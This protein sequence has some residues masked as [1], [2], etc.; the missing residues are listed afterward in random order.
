[1][2]N[3]LKAK[4]PLKKHQK[5]MLWITLSSLLLFTHLECSWNANYLELG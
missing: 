5:S 2:V 4:T 3:R 1:M